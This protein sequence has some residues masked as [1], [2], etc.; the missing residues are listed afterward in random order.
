MRGRGHETLFRLL[1]ADVQDE[2]WILKFVR[3]HHPPFP[4]GGE[5]RLG[6]AGFGRRDGR[7]PP[8]SMLVRQLLALV[9]LYG[10]VVM[11][12]E[13]IPGHVN[14]CANPTPG[15][16]ALVATPNQEVER[17]AM[18]TRRREKQTTSLKDRLIQ[19]AESLRRQA[20]EMP[21]GVRRDELL[22]KARQAE[23]AARVDDWLASPGL[24][25]PQ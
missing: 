20:E 2:E 3:H 15:S 10:A 25:P 23:T 8:C 7:L 14:K 5:R 13:K 22:R 12:V 24:Q 6:L 21:A 16:V 9:I 19:E 11:N 4:A 18:S 1:C 17:I